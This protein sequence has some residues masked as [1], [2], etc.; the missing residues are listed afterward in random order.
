MSL[1]NSLLSYQD[2]T[3]IMDSAMADSVGAR[4]KF[5]SEA[6][7]LHF[8]S[9]CHYA[10]K[11]HREQ[12]ARIYTDPEHPQHGCSHYDALVL[13]LRWDGDFHYVDLEKTDAGQIEV[14]PLSEAPKLE[15]RPQLQLTH[16]MPKLIETIVK[17]RL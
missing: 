4:A 5:A 1:S 15:H 7:A 6:E 11:L 9:R 8:R 14:T 16:E 17:R 3:E 13:R 10:R 12:N 2:C